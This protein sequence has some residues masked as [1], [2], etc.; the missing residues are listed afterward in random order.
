MPPDETVLLPRRVRTLEI[1]QREL[2]GRLDAMHLNGH[3]AAIRA[4]ADASPELVKLATLVPQLASMVEEKDDDDAF[5]REL[6][7]RVHWNSG[8]KEAVRIIVSCVIA[9]AC[10]VVAKQLGLPH[11]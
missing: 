9:V 3:A 10:W 2:K 1:G 6:K 4:L 11:P 5:V 7:R 8:T